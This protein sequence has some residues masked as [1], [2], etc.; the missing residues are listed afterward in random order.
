MEKRNESRE[1]S[2]L[3]SGQGEPSQ[4]LATS[5][6]QLRK[7]PNYITVNHKHYVP[8]FRIVLEERAKLSPTKRNSGRTVCRAEVGAISL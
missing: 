1:P 6:R 4:P 5:N 3:F 7:S 8:Q 2:R